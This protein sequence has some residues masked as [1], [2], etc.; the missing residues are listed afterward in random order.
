MFYRDILF[1]LLWT[2]KTLTPV[3]GQPPALSAGE[4]RRR[5]TKRVLAKCAMRST[6]WST[7]RSPIRARAASTSTPSVLPA[8]TK[9]L[10]AQEARDRQSHCTPARP[11]R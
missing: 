8:T 3:F 2:G 10:T 4:G 9:I 5:S 1:W 7:G 11:T 6:A